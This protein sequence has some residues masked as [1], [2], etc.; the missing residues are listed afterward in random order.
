MEGR[1]AIVHRQTFLG[2]PFEDIRMMGSR[3]E[4]APVR[5][6]CCLLCVCKCKLHSRQQQR[7]FISTPIH[8]RE[9]PAD[10][11]VEEKEHGQD[12]TVPDTHW[13]WMMLSSAQLRI[14]DDGKRR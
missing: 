7:I 10:S 9:L 1:E 4:S 5:M 12:N 14:G 8:A 11:P 13:N 6:G 3:M 2:M